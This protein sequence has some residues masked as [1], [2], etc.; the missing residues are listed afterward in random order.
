MERS[1]P[2]LLASKPLAAPRARLFCIPFAGGGAQAFA[3]WPDLVP[4]GVEVVAVQLP[5][6]E[7]RMREAAVSNLDELIAALQPAIAQRLDVPYFLFGHSMGALIAYELARS[8]QAAGAP[9]PQRLMVSGRVAPHLK[10]PREPINGL[11][12]SDFV[13]ALRALKGTPEEV[14]GDLEL[15][16]LIMPVLR[17][18]FALNEK[19]QHVAEPRLHCDVIAF[20]GIGDTEAGRA[21]VSAWEDATEGSFVLRMVPGDHFYPVT[22]AALFLRMLSVEMYQALGLSSSRERQVIEG[23]HIS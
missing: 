12:E 6:R 16:R 20:G 5:G 15:M 4:A 22:A 8:L 17:A 19:Y 13:E 7:S 21:G 2:W 11:D 3:R 1:T 9:A 10:P 14:L 23:A 18:D